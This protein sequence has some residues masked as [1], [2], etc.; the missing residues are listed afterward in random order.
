MTLPNKQNLPY[1]ISGIAFSAAA[2]AFGGW[3]NSE[4]RCAEREAEIQTAC[5]QRTQQIIADCE[6]QKVEAQ[7][8]L[9]AFIDKSS[10]RYAELQRLQKRQK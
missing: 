8:R 9:E 6:A 2:F 1:W 7:R 4:Q 10:E 3:I 5:F